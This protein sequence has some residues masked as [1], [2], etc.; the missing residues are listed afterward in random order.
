MN[1]LKL[2]ECKCGCG[3]VID[4]TNPKGAIVPRTHVL[5]AKTLT[6]NVRPIKTVK[7][8]TYQLN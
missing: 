4:L 1:K 6:L 5:D 8:Q 2:I 7:L 3:L